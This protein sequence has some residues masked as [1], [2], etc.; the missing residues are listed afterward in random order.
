MTSDMLCISSIANASSIA[1]SSGS[2]CSA[3]WQANSVSG[4]K[5]FGVPANAHV[6]RLAKLGVDLLQPALEAL[7]QA[8]DLGL[9]TEPGDHHVARCAHRL[10]R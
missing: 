2:P 7:T 1:R 8:R 9:G 4:R 5:C 3:R 10:T 6:E